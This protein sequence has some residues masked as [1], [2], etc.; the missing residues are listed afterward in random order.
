MVGNRHEMRGWV[1]CA[2]VLF[3]RTSRSATCKVLATAIEDRVPGRRV[4]LAVG[5][6]MTQR[7]S[8]PAKQGWETIG[9]SRGQTWP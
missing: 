7:S 2:V 1:A 6:G 5:M 3:G 9:T 8:A 4:A